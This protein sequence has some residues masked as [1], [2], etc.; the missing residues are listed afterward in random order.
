MAT[1]K[2]KQL[3]GAF[4]N[5]D[6]V[7]WA[8]RLRSPFLDA[9][10]TYFPLL[11]NESQFVLLLPGL[12]WFCDHDIARRFALVAFLVAYLANA[13]K[14]LLCLPRPPPRMHVRANSHVAQQYG[15]PSTHS[16]HAIALAS[17]LAREAIAS[18][19]A[20][21]GLAWPLA[22]VHVLHVCFSRL[23]MGVHSACDIVGGLVIG[24]VVVIMMEAGGRQAEGI[25]VADPLAKLATAI[26][27]AASLAFCYPDRRL[28]NTAYTELNNFGGLFI[29]ACIATGPGSSPMPPRLSVLASSGAMATGLLALG[30][31][32]MVLSAASKAAIARAP[33]GRITE[34]AEL[35]RH[36]LLPKVVAVYVLAVNPCTVWQ[37]LQ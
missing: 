12:S 30:I 11:G 6:A 1:S 37:K 7:V 36:L 21:P 3:I 31:V 18:G 26:I 4:V 25:V 24:T 34:A 27:T 22:G 17:L 19:V 16:A 33:P 28:A 23:Y 8:Q 10:F 13:T 14:D 5:W 9:W 15:F 35:L 29:G 2:P 32:R 20:K